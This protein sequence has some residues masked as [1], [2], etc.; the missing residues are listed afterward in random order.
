[1]VQRTLGI[2]IANKYLD[3]TDALALAMC[4]FY[5]LN[6]PLASVQSGFSWEKFIASNPNRVKKYPTV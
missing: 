2:K 5:Q 4:H 3:A 6:S 1:M